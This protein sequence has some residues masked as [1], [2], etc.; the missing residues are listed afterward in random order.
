MSYRLTGLGLMLL[1]AVTGRA[2]AAG[3]AFVQLDG[4]T[5]G[6]WVGWSESGRHLVPLPLDWRF[7][8]PGEVPTRVVLA[9]PEHNA[10]I[11]LPAG[12]VLRALGA[13]RARVES[14]FLRGRLSSGAMRLE[15]PSQPLVLAEGSLF[16]CSYEAF[17]PTGQ[18]EVVSIQTPVPSVEVVLDAEFQVSFD[19]VH[20]QTDPEAGQGAR[21]RALQLPGLKAEAAPKWVGSFGL[22]SPDGVRMTRSRT[23]LTFDTERAGW[24]EL[25]GVAVRARPPVLDAPRAAVSLRRGTFRRL[26]R[27]PLPC[28]VRELDGLMAE[29]VRLSV[30][31]APEVVSFAASDTPAG[32]TAVLSGW[33]DRRERLGG[34][35]T[36]PLGEVIEEYLLPLWFGL[37]YDAGTGREEV[38]DPAS[39]RAFVAAYA[40]AVDTSRPLLAKWLESHPDLLNTTLAQQEAALEV[41]G[42]IVHDLS[43]G[44]RRA[45]VWWSVYLSDLLTTQ[46]GQP[47]FYWERERLLNAPVERPGEVTLGTLAKQV[48]RGRATELQQ[49]LT[50]A[51][52][53]GETTTEVSLRRLPAGADLPLDLVIS[54]GPRVP[55]GEYHATVRLEADGVEAGSES[56]TVRVAPSLGS[57]AAVGFVA[58][59]PLALVVGLAACSRLRSRRA[60][61]AVWR[62]FLRERGPS[63]GDAQAAAEAYRALAAAGLTETLSP[64][65]LAEYERVRAAGG[66]G[67]AAFVERVAEELRRPS[68]GE[69]E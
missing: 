40:A 25:D 41:L 55:P 56:L 34:W 50:R 43:A 27:V 32:L 31:G 53:K 6:S 61:A 22:W 60:R 29:R 62:A 39:V 30:S 45:S 69:T 10:T 28:R 12:T 35:P 38:R 64:E 9:G 3:R 42:K 63:L 46:T 14:P 17:G 5:A 4:S 15:L 44:N 48:A 67:F 24:S 21:C 37:W 65:L 59:L 54:A 18:A 19:R 16:A 47:V 8:A 57:V 52:A 68:P 26:V 20:W 13:V 51:L 33:A 7:V 66:E 2:G 49:W 58:A 36:D 11:D 1:L 23:T